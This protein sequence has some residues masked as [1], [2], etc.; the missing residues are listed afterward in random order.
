[1]KAGAGGVSDMPT[2]F[3]LLAIGAATL[4]W[5]V[6]SARSIMAGLH[7]NEL[8]LGLVLGGWLVLI[9]LATLLA[10]VW[11]RGRAELW[12]TACLLLVPVGV[13]GSLL[14]QQTQLPAFSSVGRTLP[15][16]HAMGLI[17]L[18]LAPA[19]LPL[20]GAFGACARVLPGG[21]SPAAWGA[22]IYFI[23][24]LGTVLAGLL[25]H[26]VLT[27]LSLCWAALAAGALTWGTALL[28]WPVLGRPW[29]WFAGGMA[30]VSLL[31]LIYLIPGLSLP[32]AWLLEPRVPG[33]QI[34]RRVNS[35]HAALTV[36]SRGDQVLISANGQVVWSNQ[37]DAKAEALVH[38][39]MLMHPTPERVLL[40]SG[41]LGGGLREVLKHPVERIDYVELDP[42]LIALVREFGGDP[43][44]RALG[45]PRV[46]LQITDGRQFIASRRGMYDVILVGLPGPSSAL[47]N[48]F[49]TEEFLIHARAA[50]R[51]GGII[52]LLSEGSE[53]Y[54]TEQ[55]A[56]THATLLHALV[57]I[58][59][60]SVILPGG[61]TLLLAGKNSAPEVSFPTLVQRL[62]ARNLHLEHFSERSLAARLLSFKQEQVRRHLAEVRP[63]PNTDLHPAAYFHESLSWI[64]LSAPRISHYLV[65]R[66]QSAP[67]WFPWLLVILFILVLLWG[68]VRG[69]RAAGLAIFTAGFT[70]MVLEIC[71]VLAAQESRGVIYHELAALLSAFMLGLAV[72]ARVGGWLVNRLPRWGL[73]MAMILTGL[74]ALSSWGAAYWAT[75]EPSVALLILLP[76]LAGLG[77]AV[78][79]CFPPAISQMADARG[80]RA[81]A[82]GKR[83]DARGETA[84]GRAYAWDLLGG[85]MGALAGSWLL[86]PVLGLSSVC[87][88][89]GVMCL[90][91]G[92]TVWR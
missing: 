88:L 30:A 53:G 45:D 76:C 15:P 67:R 19:C 18:C 2:L 4:I 61:T 7:G 36:M 64:A 32:G 51:P 55:Q 23:E 29:R 38:T 83:A 85:A 58:M 9:G 11:S 16:I 10:A 26:F 81:D 80:K 92:L 14:L 21:R 47:V 39:S 44:R 91:M 65:E 12:L 20:G 71:L 89:C 90:A 69:H 77:V 60:N 52:R 75:R 84:V 46:H 50:L 1:M 13:A 27:R 66:A 73:S 6:A 86:I 54:L 37:E 62:R 31:A 24:S 3:P 57:K 72:G 28:L 79:A 42:A 34:Q 56:L 48:R 82:R 59:G 5:Q 63:L 43:V 49:Y 22:R 35:A 70:G 78:G 40:I 74:M 41:G 33:Y 17:L 8:I 25:F 68:A 87:L